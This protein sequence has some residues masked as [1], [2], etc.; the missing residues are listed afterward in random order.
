MGDADSAR[1]AKHLGCIDHSLKSLVKIFE[2][3]NLNFVDF[4]KKLEE[5]DTV[6]TMDTAHPNPLQVVQEE[7]KPMTRKEDRSDAGEIHDLVQDINQQQATS[8]TPTNI[9]D[10]IPAD[11]PASP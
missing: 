9:P 5:W 8:G 4:A 3:V 2:T 6:V 11:P 10:N 7:S 1:I